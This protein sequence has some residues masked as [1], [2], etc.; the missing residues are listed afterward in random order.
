MVVK[1]TNCAKNARLALHANCVLA[2]IL[3]LTGCAAVTSPVVNGVP[4]HMLPDDLLAESKENLKLIPP[5]WL[6]GTKR[7]NY[8]LDTGDILAVLVHETLP[9]GT[10]ILP[11]NFPDSSSL[12]PTTGVPIPIRENGTISMPLIGSVSLRGLTIEEAEQKVIDAYVTNGGMLN[13]DAKTQISV[14]LARP[15][16]IRVLVI[17]DDSPGQQSQYEDPGFRLSSSAQL[18][19]RRGSGFGSVLEMP[20]NEADLIDALTRTGGYPGPHGTNEVFI[21]RG[22]YGIG[23]HESPTEWNAARPE[24][25]RQQ[26]P[27]TIRIPMMIDA[28]TTERP[29]SAEDVTLYPDDIVH[30]PARTTDVYYTG[31]LL[32]AREVPLPRDYDVRALEAVL[33]VGGSL[34][35]GGRLTNNFTG[36]QGNEGLG[37]TNPTL[38]TVIRKV[39]GGGQVNIRVDLNKALTD[40]S[41]NLLIKEGDILLLQE[42]P[43][44][45]V[46]RYVSQ[47]F[48]FNAAVE[49]LNRGS[50]AASGTARLP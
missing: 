46:A 23:E 2:A 47:I 43:S 20:H 25:N 3:A 30:V 8:K 7:E 41:S 39:P 50:A 48:N 37:P 19:T 42:T 6:K 10:Q 29:F 32:P 38:L 12:P 35:N 28:N 45:A 44:E 18:G 26:G 13:E 9:K 49:I 17:R 36:Q 5:T 34:V 11:V 24:K 14:N 22:Y 27:T 40:S 4:A 21:Y 31:G 16:Q 33:R 15:R 1:P